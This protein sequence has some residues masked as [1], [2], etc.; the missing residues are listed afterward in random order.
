MCDP[1][2]WE[3]AGD[4]QGAGGFGVGDAHPKRPTSE[5]LSWAASEREAKPTFLRRT[6][7]SFLPCKR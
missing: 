5:M 4:I 6:Q 2:K 3:N 1:E 7:N